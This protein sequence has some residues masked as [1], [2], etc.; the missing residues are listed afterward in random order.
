LV[1]SRPIQT[2]PVKNCSWLCEWEYG[3]LMVGIFIM[4][5]ANS[6]PRKARI[7]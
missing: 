6:D 4:D 1:P 2:N 5:L 7:E 3:L